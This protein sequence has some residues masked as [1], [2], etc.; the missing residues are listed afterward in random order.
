[1]T[2]LLIPTGYETMFLLP[3]TILTIFACLPITLKVLNKNI[4]PSNVI[5]LSFGLC[6]L[7]LA[8]ISTL[9]LR[10][11]NT[12]TIFAGA[13]I[14]D[15]M[16]TF[17]NLGIIVVAGL[18]LFLSVSGVNTK[19]NSFAEHTFLVLLSAV[20]MLTLTSAGDLIVAFI[21]LEIMSI[22]LYVLIGIGHEQRFSKEAALK[23]FILGSFASA[24]FLYGIAFIYGTANTTHLAPLASQAVMLAETSRLFVAGIILLFVGVGFK[25]SLFPFHAWT[26]DVY[27]GA[28]T[29]VSGFM[30]TGVKLVMFTFLLR[31]AVLH[32]FKTDPAFISILQV[33]AVLTMTIGNITAIVQENIKRVIAYSSIAHAGYILVAIIVASTSNSPDAA[34]AALFYLMAYSVMN[35]GAFAIVNIFEKEERG[36]LSITDYAGLGFKYPFLGAALS[37]FMLSLAGIPPTAGFLGKFFIFA[38]AVKE[39]Y[40]GLAIF[41]VINSLLSVYYY[42]RILVYLYMKEPVFSVEAQP[43]YSSRF[44]VLTT[45]ILTLVMGLFSASFYEP[46]FRSVVE[47]I[48]TSVAKL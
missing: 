28:P 34:T 27:Q 26:P 33:V 4:E 22:A 12:P 35:L 31:L 9:M 19:N 2:H 45:L 17:A 44:V 23:Y 7:I 11:A 13:L 32:I 41:G 8:A 20:G 15:K 39:N 5:T 25:V 46:A 18:T 48:L 36:N 47:L 16:A 1:M 38:A 30:A 6:G 42:L 14:F 3:M 24:I 40:M 37:I 10:S 43:G 29:S 21:G